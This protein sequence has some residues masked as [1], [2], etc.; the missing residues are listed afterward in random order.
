MTDT[1]PPEPSP[2][3]LSAG[4]DEYLSLDRRFEGVE[5]AVRRIWRRMCEVRD[6]ELHKE[7]WGTDIG[8]PE[9]RKPWTSIT[10]L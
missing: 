1:W 2:A 7:V 6:A 9:V 3:M 4:S 10:F 5:D 8:S